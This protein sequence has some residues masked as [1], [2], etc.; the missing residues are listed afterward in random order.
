MRFAIIMLHDTMAYHVQRA[1][2]GPTIWLLR[3]GGVV[4]VISGKNILKSDFEHK[5]N[6]ARKYLPYNSFVCQGKI[7]YHQRFGEKK[8]LR[9]PIKS[10]IPRSKSNG[11]EQPLMSFWSNFKLS[12]NSTIVVTRQ[13]NFMIKKYLLS[14]TLICKEWGSKAW[15]A[16]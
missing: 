6:L 2:K 9:R 7:F 16:S 10:P 5:K 4:R 14:P 11:V 13:V 15:F 1:Y 12:T 3:G 8:F